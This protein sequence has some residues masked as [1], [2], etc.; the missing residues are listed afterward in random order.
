MVFQAQRYIYV[1]V[2]QAHGEDRE[3]INF[4][5][6][7]SPFV[8]VFRKYATSAYGGKDTFESMHCTPKG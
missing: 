2:L 1:M 5:F 6:R 4:E 7:I 8:F 3:S